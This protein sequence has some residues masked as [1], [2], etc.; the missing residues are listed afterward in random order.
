MRNGQ[1][2]VF[3]CPPLIITGQQVLEEMPKLDEVLGIVD[4]EML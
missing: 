2:M 3:V 4:R 1:G